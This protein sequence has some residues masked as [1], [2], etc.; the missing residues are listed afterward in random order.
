MLQSIHIE[1]VALIKKLDIDLSLLFV[2]SPVKQVPARALLSTRSVYFAVE[3]FLKN[4][5]ETVKII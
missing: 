4:L 1:N 5:S 2:L 3:E